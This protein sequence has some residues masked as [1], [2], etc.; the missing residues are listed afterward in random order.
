M[1]CRVCSAPIE[2]FMSF[3]KMPIANGFLTP[4]Q[5]ENEYFFELA[6]AFC[7]S[8]CTLQLTK[9]PD[10]EKMFH[11]HY[12]F[13]SRTS[14]HMVKHFQNYAHWV[15][16]NYLDHNPFVIEL[17]SNDGILLE[18]FSK[19]GISHMGVEPSANVANIAQQHGVNSI[20]AFFSPELAKQ[21]LQQ[22]GKADAIMAANVM[23]HIPD[24]N[25]IA[26]GVDILLKEQGVLI[27]EDP[28]LGDMVR[29]VSYDQLYDEHVY[30][31]SA[32][33]VNNIFGRHGFELIDLLPQ[34]THGGSMRYVLA[35]KGKRPISAR[36]HDIL[37]T[38]VELGL[39]KSGTFLKFKAQCESSKKELLETLRS[40]K[41][42]GKRVVGYAATSKSTTVLNYCQITPDLIEF[43][44]DTTPE[45]QGKYSPGMHI[46]IKPYGSFCDAYPDYAV[47][48][49]WNHKDEIFAKE[50]TFSESGGQWITFVQEVFETVE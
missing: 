48:F 26:E 25:A 24:L 35:R 14:K 8:C 33:S 19:H 23:C 1:K 29:R 17:G 6:P 41:T 10:P 12:A 9:Q 13:F 38:E 30:I 43:I 46:P 27:F 40:L 16:D 21:I 49:A 34:K 37:Q 3:G 39:D 20:V 47:L 44:A 45:K 50:Q 4:E 2:A 28:Y 7:S 32:I 42:E 31:F 36:V 5:F 11:D 15:M 18:N 22:Q